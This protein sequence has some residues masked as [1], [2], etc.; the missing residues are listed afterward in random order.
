MRRAIMSIAILAACGRP[1]A[2]PFYQTAEM[3]PE[4]LNESAATHRVAPFRLKDQQA[5]TITNTAFSNRVTIVHFFFTRCGDVC[6]TTTT[7]IARTLRAIDNA[8]LQVLSHSVTPEAD[9][10]AALRH[11]A[12]AH[13]IVDPR[14]HLVTNLAAGAAVVALGLSGAGL[15]YE[16]AYFD[17]TTWSAGGK[18]PINK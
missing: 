13:S 9:S 15:V 3:T 6:P 17:G 11:Y 7:N 16:L 12:E 10:V 4:W 18:S 2:L 5:R 14:W 1:A 8:R